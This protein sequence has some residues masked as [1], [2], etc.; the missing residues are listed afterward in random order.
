VSPLLEAR[1]TVGH[2]RLVVGRDIEVSVRES[3]ICAVVGP[4]GA[5]KTTLLATIA[6][7]LPAISGSVSI[8]GEVL[9]TGSARR[10]S[11]AGVTLVPDNR[12]LFT[13]LTTLENLS[14]ADRTGGQAIDEVFELFP[15]LR[16]K[17]KLEAGRLSGGEQQMLA[18]G[19]ALVQQ[20]RVL[21]IDEMSMGL[22]PLV[23]QSLVR[24]IRDL[25]SN[26][27]MAVVLVEQHVN[28]ALDAADQAIVLVHG[29]V[30]MQGAAN[31]VAANPD[32]GSAYL[33][34]VSTAHTP[35]V[36]S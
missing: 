21:L 14:V 6:G 29:D 33:G 20:P 18:L 35:V 15:G 4:N 22:A 26:T 27:G 30:V 34:S 28:V 24:T 3:E 13:T 25:A 11:R 23:V 16:A 19:R 17:Q 9:A 31:E 10:M 8:A 2:G 36:G 7:L 1:L 32:L 12:A 5:G